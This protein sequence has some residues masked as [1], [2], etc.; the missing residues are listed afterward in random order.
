MTT[1]KTTASAAPEREL[2]PNERNAC[3]GRWDDWLEVLL[4]PACNGCCAWCVER[5]GWHPEKRATPHQIA[6]AALGTR[7]KYIM[8]LGGEPTLYPELDGIIGTL[9][10]AGRGV[11]VTTNG[12]R[13]HDDGVLRALAR[14][15]RVNLSIHH[16]CL[17]ANARITGIPLDMVNLHDAVAFLVGR[18]VGVRLN[19]NII[20]G[21]IDSIKM[22]EYYAGFARALGIGSVR[23]A[24]L[25]HSGEFIS[26]AQICQQRWGLNEDPYRLGCWREAQAWGIKINLRQM[27]GWQEPSRPKYRNPS[28]KPKPVLYYD[29]QLYPGWQRKRSMDP[30]DAKALKQLLED[31]AAGR[32]TPDQAAAIIKN[33]QSEKP[34]PAPNGNCTY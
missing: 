10:D 5:T 4:T 9:S 28:P 19:C 17:A 22:M 15:Y 25:R 7:C 1:E 2:E 24:E 14:C 30:M 12:S 32:K 29:G 3:A 31:V 11:C 13:L 6:A 20:R 33:Q 27:C 16:F 18:G 23:F 26:L 34:E 21:Q 8:L